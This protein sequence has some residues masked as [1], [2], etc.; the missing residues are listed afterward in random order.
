[1]K[2]RLQIITEKGDFLNQENKVVEIL[3]N[4]LL[5][6]EKI[7]DNIKSGR[8]LKLWS[9]FWFL[10]SEN[11]KD[12]KILPCCDYPY[13]EQPIKFEGFEDL[14][15][16]NY[17]SI[18]PNNFNEIIDRHPI[19]DGKEL[20]LKEIPLA[21]NIMIEIINILIMM[22]IK[23]YRAFWGWTGTQAV[24]GITNSI[25]QWITL[26]SSIAE[27][28]KKESKEHY[29]RCYRWIRWEA[30]KMIIMARN[31][32]ELRGNYY[33]GLYLEE[34]INYMQE[35]HF[36]T[37]PM[38]KDVSKMDEW[39]GVFGKDLEKDI[40]GVLDKV[41]GIRHKVIVGKEKKDNE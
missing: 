29:N 31:D 14:I 16:S 4:I 1:L 28:Q 32:V 24:W 40:I 11:E 7:T 9:R 41:K 38:F 5:S 3:E 26:E 34:L 13:E 27:Q 35:H 33:V 37:M 2:R 18:Y 21:I 15:P 12:N 39:R 30:E 22:W 25:F 17:H 10:C 23:Y 20:G 36:D 19:L 6:N 8:E